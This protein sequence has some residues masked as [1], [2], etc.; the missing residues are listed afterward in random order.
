VLAN[1][2]KIDI[3]SLQP[4]MYVAQLDRPWLETPFIEQGFEIRDHGDISRLRAYCKHVYVDANRGSVSPDRVIAATQRQAVYT[5]RLGRRSDVVTQRIPALG[6][7]LLAVLTRLDPSGQLATRFSRDLA[8]CPVPLSREAPRALA[9]YDD[10]VAALSAVST[11]VRQGQALDVSKLLEVIGPMT[12][13]LLRN[14]DAMAWLVLTRQPDQQSYEP[15]TGPAVWAVMLGQHLGFEREDLETLALGGMLLDIGMARIPPSILAHDGEPSDVEIEIMRK[16]VELGISIAG[17]TV[18]L[19][20]GVTEMITT[21]HEAHDGS[22]YPHARSGADIPL[23]GRIAGLVACFDEMVGG[24]FGTAVRAPAEAVLELNAMA[25][26]KFQRELIEHFVRAV[27]MFPTGSFVELN[28]GA[29]GLVVGQNRVRRLRPRVLLL[30][31]S[32]GRRLRRPRIM[33]LGRVPSGNG[34]ARARWIVRGLQ[35]GAHGL[36]AKEYLV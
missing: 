22:G 5:E 3:A 30:L 25:D 7:Q 9:A 8:P 21:H 1:R 28:N 34:R 16:H 10:A 6:R 15:S 17:K 4:G 24:R 18:G 29:V 11:E 13:S 12:D 27:G 33:D 19:P 23:F 36:D 35:A 31:D 26:A 14:H 2:T 20:A 32:N